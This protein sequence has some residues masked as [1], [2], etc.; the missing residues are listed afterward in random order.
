MY[1]YFEWLLEKIG[2]SNTCAIQYFEKCV[3]TYIEKIVSKN[4]KKNIYKDAWTYNYDI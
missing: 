2:E 3:Y 1:I 4:M